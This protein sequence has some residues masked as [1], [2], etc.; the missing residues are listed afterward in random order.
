[1]YTNKNKTTYAFDDSLCQNINN[2]NA[3]M[4]VKIVSKTMFR[5]EKSYGGDYWIARLISFDLVD[6]AS[7]YKYINIMVPTNIQ[8]ITSIPG[9]ITDFKNGTYIIKFPCYSRIIF[10]KYTLQVFLMRTSE[11]I[12]ANI[13]AMTTMNSQNRNLEAWI[14]D[15]DDN[16]SQVIL[17]SFL[18]KELYENAKEKN[19]CA[20]YNKDESPEKFNTNWYYEK[21]NNTEKCPKLQKKY[22][23]RKRYKINCCYVEFST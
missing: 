17:G 16:H 21:L 2:L 8:N 5:K 9:N 3:Y 19:F 14:V 1:M 20:V 7:P 11:S 18:K 6:R 10:G 15:S 22:V 13:K 4:S 12:Q 23:I